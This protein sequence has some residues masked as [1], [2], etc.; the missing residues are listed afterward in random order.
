MYTHQPSESPLPSYHPHHQHHVTAAAY[1]FP[2][3]T[4][5]PIPHAQPIYSAN[6][7]LPTSPS[8]LNPTSRASA[9]CFMPPKGNGDDHLLVNANNGIC[10]MN[11]S[12]SSPKDWYH[13]HSAMEQSHQHPHQHHH[14]PQ[15]YQH[16]QFPVADQQSSTSSFLG[17]LNHQGTSASIPPQP[18]YQN[19][20]S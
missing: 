15:P 16:Y 2:A 12:S 3:P 6:L 1:H 9:I 5:Q 7:P 17:Y 8:D 18:S 13:Q 11:T 14:Q 10:P 20:T 19:S 4:P